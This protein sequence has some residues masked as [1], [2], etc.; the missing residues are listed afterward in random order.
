MIA[1][2]LILLFAGLVALF[3][4]RARRANKRESP[5]VQ[6][7]PDV[8]IFSG[9]VSES[10]PIPVQRESPVEH[11][12][13]SEIDQSA[14]T[15]PSEV[16]SAT[17]PEVS[18]RPDE[19]Q[20]DEPACRVVTEDRNA[21]SHV[22]DRTLPENAGKAGYEYSP[23]KSTLGREAN[24]APE[25]LGEESSDLSS[26]VD[27]VTPGAL[28]VSHDQPA[29]SP[30]VSEPVSIVETKT[31]RPPEQLLEGE[32]LTLASPLSEDFV[33]PEPFSNGHLHPEGLESL[34]TLNESGS[35]AG[36]D[37]ESRVSPNFP[38]SRSES[39][40][41]PTF[42]N[43]HELTEVEITRDEV[44]TKS[45]SKEEIESISD[46]EAIPDVEP[47]GNQTVSTAQDSPAQGGGRPLTE[48]HAEVGNTSLSRKTDDVEEIENKHSL[49]EAIIVTSDAS[50]GNDAENS[51]SE[52]TDAGSTTNHLAGS[53]EYLP[54]CEAEKS[55]QL[56]EVNCVEPIP[57]QSAGYAPED[58]HEE[59]P[60]RYRSPQQGGQKPAPARNR[61]P[62]SKPSGAELEV[63][64]HITLQ[65]DGIREIG[66]LPKRTDDLDDKIPVRLHGMVL[67][68]LAQEDWYQDLQLDR[69]GD[70]LRQGLELN[71]TLANGN[72][73][74]WLLTGRELYVLASHPSASGFIST[75]RLVLGRSHVVLCTLEAASQVEALLIQAGCTGLSRLEESEGAP[76]GW[77]VFRGVTPT[78]SIPLGEGSDQFYPVKPAPD[79]EL[80]LEGGI[81]LRNS[82]WLSEHPP[83]IR[84]LGENTESIEVLIDGK[85]T[86]RT[87][88][89]NLIADGYDAP[90]HHVV[91]CSGASCSCSYAI[92]NST[93]SWNEWKAYFFGQADICGPLVRPTLPAANR[94]MVEVAMT[95]LLILGS[96]PGQIY[97]CK[98][99]PGNVWKGFV[100]FEAVWALPLHPLLCEK[101][102][103]RILAQAPIDV[104]AESGRRI[105]ADDWCRA[106]L[107]ASRKGLKVDDPT[108]ASQIRWI[109]YQKLARN[110]WRGAK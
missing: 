17:I 92:E 54:S 62:G 101:M 3:I 20:L 7:S 31:S 68:L 34:K 33:S 88:E 89:G 78:K 106:I 36:L 108:G 23:F 103:S 18:T 66:L 24:I 11:P 4:C 48:E 96:K 75:A 37:E 77:C 28:V 71:G 70:Y 67:E 81:C 19:A 64:V 97:R 98:M 39:Q 25:H 82:N 84:L 14:E 60:R 10:P 102:S 16:L 109:S 76:A 43:I 30:T 69:M 46:E 73:V 93:D 45:E 56:P 55:D 22:P 79:I 83:E 8:P 53:L 40:P 27:L 44:Q 1:I 2:T 12:T 105:A 63:R 58:E 99:R 110:I 104:S 95:N 59:K 74:R 65:R 100:P 32:R 47:N 50:G 72:R 26:P 13:K 41:Q 51:T 21:Q 85:A 15:Q 42:N 29:E 49:D 9:Q 107:D 35:S 52:I 86:H 90:G 5:Y 80:Q 6:A 57:V 61:T 38:P 87:V 94:K 91:V